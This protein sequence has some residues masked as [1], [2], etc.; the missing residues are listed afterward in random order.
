MHTVHEHAPTTIWS[1]IGS[2]TACDCA[3]A[4]LVRV[5]HHR[6]RSV[7][8]HGGTKPLNPLRYDVAILRLEASTLLEGIECLAVL[9]ND[10]RAPSHWQIKRD[11]GEGEG[12][13]KRT[14]LGR[15]QVR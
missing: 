13:V 5:L 8:S 15:V 11:R 4:K 3:A 10:R 6:K 12:E 1:V 9:V 7:R 14:S 2:D